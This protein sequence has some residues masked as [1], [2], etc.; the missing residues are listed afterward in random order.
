MIRKGIHSKQANK[1]EDGYQRLLG[2]RENVVLHA[3]L[4]V[5]SFLI[6]GAVPV[7]ICGILVG[8]NY[9]SEV[10]VTDVVAAYALFCL[11]P[12]R[13]T[14]KDSPNPTSKRCRIMLP[15]RLQLRE[16]LN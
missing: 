14:P 16:R 10:K 15:W 9:S 7:V 3:D 1:Q 5:L 2:R 12:A 11:Q 13:L 8:E 4:A 6:F